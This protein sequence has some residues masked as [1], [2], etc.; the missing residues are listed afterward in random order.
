LAADTIQ[1]TFEAVLLKLFG[2]EKHC[3]YFPNIVMSIGF[4]YTDFKN[5]GHLPAIMD[6][7]T[8]RKEGTI[9]FE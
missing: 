2:S 1:R 9:E 4:I 7:P 6:F 8:G 5:A 3:E